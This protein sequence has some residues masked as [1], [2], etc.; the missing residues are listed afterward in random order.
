MWRTT[1][2]IARAVALTSVMALCSYPQTLKIWPGVAP[3]SETWTQQER[4]EKNTPIGTVVFNVV[5][6]TL[7]VYLPERSKATGTGIII[8][9]AELSWRWL[10]IWKAIMWR[11]GFRTR[12]LPR[13]C[14]S[15][16]LW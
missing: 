5:T 7:T 15:T 9:R 6:P 3:G 12:A 13:S 2:D 11:S 14:L 4:V 1:F 16:A 10:S 8:A